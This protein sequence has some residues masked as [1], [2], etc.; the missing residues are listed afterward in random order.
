M[1]PINISIISPEAGTGRN[2]V[3]YGVAQA[4]AASKKVAL[5]RPIACR[6]E[7]LTETLLKACGSEASRGLSVATCPGKARTDRE[8][9]RADAVAAYSAL[10]AK[11]Q[12]EA[13]LIVGSDK[14]PVADP[15]RMVLD[16]DIAADLRSPVFLAVCT[17]ERTPE[18]VFQSVATCRG[19]VEG[20]GSRLAG[21]FVTGCEQ[22]D[23]PGLQERFAGYDQPCWLVDRMEF[24]PAPEATESHEQALK[25]FQSCAPA[26]Q[27][28]KAAEG[29]SVQ[30]TTPIAFQNDLLERAK[31]GQKTIV[32]PEGGEDRILKAA[33]YL[34]ERGI[35]KLIIV[36]EQA[37]IL[38]RAGELGLE[39]L[40]QASFQ[41]MDD[42]AVLTPMISKLCALRA[43]KGMTEEQARQ[44]LKDPSYFGTMLV[45]QGLADGLVSGSVNSTAN[46]VRPALQVIKTKPGASL[47]SGAFLMCFKDH[48]AVFADCAINLNPT[49]EQLADIAIQ[50]AQT[51]RAFGIEPR[52]GMLSYSTLGSGKG[53]DVDL[54]EEA[55]RLAKEKAPDLP[56]VGSIQF[57]AAWSP[58][59]AAA[60]AKGNEVAGHVNV[61]VF[62]SLAAGN[63][64]Y[65][66]VQRSS[67][68][69]AIGPVLQGLNRPVNDLSRGALVQDIINT[70]A[71]TAVEAQDE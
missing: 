16:A 47:V 20:A 58:T 39:H 42:E 49:A 26:D 52:V 23:K 33:D 71:L 24:D 10:T 61:F 2:V 63:I 40:G 15:T 41:S 51:A 57:D 5:L 9:A 55:T 27:I 7:R 68:A 13:V 35:V 17:I 22:D 38:K 65:K 1:S 19:I 31:A 62:P 60:K 70:V 69:L 66:A 36:G 37:A 18:Q 12:P 11:E 43:K 8:Q 53:P 45:V 30:V 6:K 32:L 50:S 54:V 34:L 44:Q 25:A 14:T 56:I 46:T 29:P 64:G 21:V 48:V 3:A 28:V 67:G 59:V 4:L